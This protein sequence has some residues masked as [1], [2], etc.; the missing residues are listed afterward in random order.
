MMDWSVTLRSLWVSICGV[1][2]L[3]VMN[4]PVA[5]A[6]NQLLATLDITPQATATNASYVISLAAI[7]TTNSMTDG[8]FSD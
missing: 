5:A 1:Y 7:F 3:S 6:A 4:L 2:D 8:E